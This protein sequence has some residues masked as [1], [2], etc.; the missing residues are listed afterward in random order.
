[1][2]DSPA[3]LVFFA[4]GNPGARYART[5]HNF[6]WMALEALA[7][8]W[9]LRLA[10]S[11]GAWDEA[12]GEIAGAEVTLVQ[13]LTYMNR[14]GQAAAA[15]LAQRG[16]TP[17]HLVA[18]YDDLDIPFGSLRLRK[19]GGAAG[20]RGMESLIEA[21]QTEKFPR[22]RLGLGGIEHGGETA[23]FV[24]EEFS[25]SEWPVARR[26][27]ERAADAMEGIAAGGFEAAMNQFNV[28]A[29]PEGGPGE[30]P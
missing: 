15:L 18:L 11:A 3:P 23:D 5:R 21:L 20:H 9:R 26:M 13:P 30:H 16:L 12:R 14:C 17:E 7:S 10:R 24:L 25:A 8:R 29:A 22:L 6:G 1:V 27:I 28:P 2:Q 4:L 19:Q